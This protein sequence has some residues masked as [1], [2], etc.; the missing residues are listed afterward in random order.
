MVDFSASATQSEQVSNNVVPQEGVAAP[1]IAL[2]GIM[3]LADQVFG[4]VEDKKQAENERFVA[5]FLT[6]QVAVNEALQQGSIKTRDQARTIL[7]RNFV[8]AIN[9]APGLRSDLVKAHNDALGLFGNQAEIF[10]GSDEERRIERDRNSLVDN[11]FLS[12]VHT[13]EEYL[14]ASANVRSATMAAEQLK[15]TT[16]AIDLRLKQ[17]TLASSERTRLE[18]ERTDAGREFVRRTSQVE[19]TRMQNS[20]E[21]ILA[22]DVSD[23]EKV[24]AINDWFNGFLSSGTELNLDLGSTEFSAYIKPF[25]MLRDTYI[26][27]ATGVLSDEELKRRN[28]RILETSRAIA[29]ADPEVAKLATASSLFRQETILELLLKNDQAFNTVARFMAGGDTEGPG[30]SPFVNGSLNE[31]ALKNYGRAIA[32]GL[33]SSDEEVSEESQRRLINMLNDISVYEGVLRNDARTGKALVEFMSSTEFLDAVTSGEAGLELEAASQVIEDHYSSEVWGALQREFQESDVRVIVPKTRRSRNPQTEQV[34][35]TN[36]I[37]TETVPGGMRFVNNLERGDVGFA[38][39]QRKTRQ[40]NKNVAPLVNSMIR[41]GAHLQGRDDY[42]KVWEESA[43]AFLSTQNNVAGGDEDDDLE[44]DDF[45]FPSLTNTSIENIPQE[46]REDKE[47]INSVESLSQELEVDSKVLLA[48]MDFE[49]GGEFSPSTKN[50]VGSGATGLIQFMP[51]TAR[52]LGT[53]T[54]ALSKMNRG[55]QMNY[56]R[57]Y[58]M[59][60]ADKLR[61]GNASDFYMAVLFPRA[62]DRDGSYVLFRRGTKAYSQNRGLDTNGDGTVTKAEA[63]SKVVNLIGK[64]E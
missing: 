12:P 24:N 63:A 33:K 8:S 25:E 53:T 47:F 18:Q 28:E 45:L 17:N 61:G 49:T 21:N 41:A 38:E 60:Y 20:L 1:S 59:R 3:G 44:I 22:T 57:S 31:T 42:N 54:E 15:Q 11:N 35:T 29:L 5:D 62:M 10:Q 19:F 50:K 56:V 51:D 14:I 48:I 23:T 16:D 34:P 37:E 4:M 6:E 36:I 52:E 13:E 64:Y 27:R 55:E 9:T 26:D 58:F 40:L 39:A 30:E 46:V 43:E 32:E 7:R 2:E